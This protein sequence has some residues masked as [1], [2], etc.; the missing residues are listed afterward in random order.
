[1]E[2]TYYLV[3]DKTSQ[4]WNV[5]LS[6]GAQAAIEAASNRAANKADR[7]LSR[8]CI[9][10]YVCVVSEGDIYR[11][12]TLYREGDTPFSSPLEQACYR[13]RTLLFTYNFHN[14]EWSIFL[15]PPYNYTLEEAKFYYLLEASYKK[16]NTLQPDTPISLFIRRKR[17]KINYTLSNGRPGKGNLSTT[18]EGLDD[19]FKKLDRHGGRKA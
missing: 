7:L 3:I 14:M 8:L 13:N 1:M 17:G 2:S 18:L 5:Q 16:G 9:Q 10:V 12:T 11:A 6:K 4:T 15:L 19:E